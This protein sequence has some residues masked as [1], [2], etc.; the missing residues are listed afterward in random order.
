MT[1]F[2][3]FR[4]LHYQEKPLLIP[5]VWDIT[6]A[7]VMEESGFRTI[8]TSSSALAQ[9]LGYA[10]GENLPFDLLLQ[11][12]SGITRHAHIPISVDME[13]GYS[14]ELPGILK[15]MDRLLDLG[16]VGINLEDSTR[17]EIRSLQKIDDFQKIISVLRDHLARNNRQMFINAR[18]DAFVV[19]LPGALEETVKRAAAYEQAGA[20]G[21]FVP[22]LEDPRQIREVAASTRLPLNVFCLPRLPS[23]PQLAELGVKRISM[24]GALFRAMKGALKS[25]V[26]RIRDDQSFRALFQGD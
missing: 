24:G 5:N 14:A 7:R 18:T 15:N 23:F 8:A 9:S 1:T 16:I 25:T 22:Y 26:T 20:D 6:S 3:S 2:E 21:I 4:E 17:N 19:K 12:V 11:T 13:K 10:D